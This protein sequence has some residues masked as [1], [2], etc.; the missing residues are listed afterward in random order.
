MEIL[1]MIGRY[2]GEIRDVR[3][4]HAHGLIERGEAI[5]PN[6]PIHTGGIIPAGEPAIV[7]ANPHDGF[8]PRA[9]AARFESELA[10]VASK[11]KAKR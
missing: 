3:P 11:K 1:M 9:V 10:N 2:A 4:H 5:D 8:V 6:S 7:G